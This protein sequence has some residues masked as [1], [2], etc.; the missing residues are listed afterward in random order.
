MRQI[1]D[2]FAAALRHC[3]GSK[4]LKERLADAWINELEDIGISELP[5]QLRAEFR[6]LR[7]SMHTAKPQPHEPVAKASIRKMSA[8]QAERETCR[9]LQLAQEMQYITLQAESLVS[10]AGHDELTFTASAPLQRLN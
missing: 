1:S 9:I 2:R 7:E 4:P 8:S 6:R 3:V 10:D 5:E